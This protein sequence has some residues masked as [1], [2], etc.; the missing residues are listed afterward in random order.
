MTFAK[1]SEIVTTRG[2]SLVGVKT[3]AS[4]ESVIVGVKAGASGD[5]TIS[6]DSVV[7]G[8]LLKTSSITFLILASLA[9][10][11]SQCSRAKACLSLLDKGLG[12]GFLHFLF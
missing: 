6:G 5:S 1:A 7:S 12:L 3:G 11:S 9:W 2:L 10:F 4:G 8:L